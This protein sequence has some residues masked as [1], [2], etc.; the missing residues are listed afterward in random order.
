MVL[1]WTG[2][3]ILILIIFVVLAV[4]ALVFTVTVLTG[5][6]GLSVN[7]GTNLT[8]A[9]AAALTALATY[10]MGRLVM[11]PRTRTLVDRATGQSYPVEI[12]DTFLWVDVRYWTYILAAI[13]AIMLAAT[14]LF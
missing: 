6:L 5:P 1:F 9:I 7:Q 14:F 11:K 13:A 4:A 3:G 12:R 8:I 10:P 2:R